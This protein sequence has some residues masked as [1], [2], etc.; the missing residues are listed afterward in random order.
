MEPS[1][2]KAE[3][4]EG[5]ETW[6]HVNTWIKLCLQSHTLLAFQLVNPLIFSESS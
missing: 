6:E 2:G 4:R 3:L 5:E 1:L